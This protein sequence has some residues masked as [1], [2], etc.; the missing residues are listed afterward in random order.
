MAYWGENQGVSVSRPTKSDRIR[1]GIVSGHVRDQSVWTAIVRGW[2]EHLDKREISLHIFYT[3]ATVD[4]ETE[5]ARTRSEFLTHGARSLHEWVDAIAEQRLDAI[6]FPEIGMDPVTVKLA[7]L[8]LAPVQIAAWGHPETTG[9]PT[10]DYYLSAEAFEPEQAQDNY[11]E[12]LVQLPNLGCAYRPL[13]VAPMDL[14]LV[15]AG[16]DPDSP[17]LICAGTPMKYAPWS[18][19]VLCENRPAIGSLPVCVLQSLQ[20]RPL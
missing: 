18:D 10:M 6:I 7:S 19:S 9:L 2:C 14:D 15:E 1:L 17:I 12:K 16:L 5:F 20:G 3:G 4:Q 13:D 8:R 11:R